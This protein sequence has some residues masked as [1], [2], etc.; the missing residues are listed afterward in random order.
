MHKRKNCA[1]AHVLQRSSQLS[2]QQ[3]DKTKKSD[4]TSVNK[5]VDFKTL[6]HSCQNGRC[7]KHL[8]LWVKLSMYA[9]HGPVILPC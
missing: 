3:T 6:S 5:D 7:C 8:A 9:P 1:M 2:T 4:E